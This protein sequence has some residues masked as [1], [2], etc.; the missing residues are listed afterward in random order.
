MGGQLSCPA[1]FVLSPNGQSCV[2]PCPSAKNYYMTSNG[3]AVVCTYSGDKTI[4]VPL[5]ATPTYMAGVSFDP[6]V[7]PTPANASYKVLPN[8]QVYKNELDRF[9][10]ALAVA[11][12]NVDK[13]VKISTAF[14]T[15]QAAENARHVAPDA[16]SAARIAYYTLV[17]GDSWL[18]EEQARIA[19]VE[20]QPVVNG[21]V[22]QYNGI[23]AKKDQQ[24]STIDVVNGVRDKILTVKDDLKFSVSTFQKQIGD[25]KNQINKDKIEQSQSIAAASSW[26]DTFL[27]WVIALVTLV[28]I[29]LLV[30]RFWSTPNIAAIESQ[31]RLLRAQASLANAKAGIPETKSWFGNA[32]TPTRS[33]AKTT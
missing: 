5:N 29:V 4:N 23:K 30:R 13:Q 19:Q 16:Y 8:A 9:A 33:T 17:K 7:Q 11:D 12:A 22:A 2:V 18:A 1:E 21:Y 32:F 3:T 25:I 20:A 24:Q 31:A 28:A 15:L 6:K 14:A 10:N 27:N 26:V